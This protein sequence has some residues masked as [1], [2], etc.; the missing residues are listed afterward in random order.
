MERDLERLAGLREVLLG[1]PGWSFDGEASF[2]SNIQVCS[3]YLNVH[4][5]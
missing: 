1:Q 2:L 3:L 4:F 5:K